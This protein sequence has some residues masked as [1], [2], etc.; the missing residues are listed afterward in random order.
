MANCLDCI[1]YHQSSDIEF[2]LIPYDQ[3]RTDTPKGQC[4]INIDLAW[5]DKPDRDGDSF[6]VLSFGKPDQFKR[7]VWFP[8]LAKV[9]LEFKKN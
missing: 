4:F 9:C 5:C 3:H 2:D 8:Q 6:S 7:D 1:H